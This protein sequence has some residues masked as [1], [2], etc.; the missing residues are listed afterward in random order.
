VETVISL[1]EQNMAGCPTDDR[2]HRTLQKATIKGSQFQNF[3]RLALYGQT[4]VEEN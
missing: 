3:S 2:S 1:E 4:E